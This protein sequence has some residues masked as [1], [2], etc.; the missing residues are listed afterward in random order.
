MS[1]NGGSME[2]RLLEPLVAYRDRYGREFGQNAA[3]KFEELLR[4]SSVNVWKNR[5]TVAA[6]RAEEAKRKEAESASGRFSSFTVLC[7][8]IAAFCGVFAILS[9]I[10]ASI[11]QADLGMWISFIVTGAALCVGASL[12][13]AK[14]LAPRK[15]ESGR[16]AE[17]YGAR[18]E[19]CMRECLAQLAP[20]EALYDDVLL[21]DLIR[22]TVPEIEL[23]ASVGAARSQY[24]R[25]HFGAAY[26]EPEKMFVGTL[27]GE[28]LGNPFIVGRKLCHRMGVRTYSE[29][30]VITWETTEVDAEGHP[31]TEHHSEVLTGYV[32]KPCPYFYGE[33][34]LEFYSE[35]APDLTFSRTPSHAERFSE[36]EIERKVRKGSKKI[37][38][39]QES[40]PGFTE[41]GNA[42]FDV[43][44]GALD[45]N[46]E[47]QFR[48]LFTPLAQKNLLSLMRGTEGFGDDF[49]M[50]KEGMKTTVVSEHSA[51]WDPDCGRFLASLSGY[52]VALAREN[53]L[54]ETL[55][56]FRNL[57]F[58]LAPILSIPLFGQTRPSVPPA[59]ARR[60]V[61][62][63]EA[64]CAAYRMGAS[65]R[66]EEA[67]T[68]CYFKTQLIRTVGKTDV[69]RVHAYGYRTEERV[70]TV[71]EYG[72][73][74]YLHDIDVPWTE[75]FPV[76]R[77]TTVVLRE[78]GLSLL[79]FGKTVRGGL[80]EV[81]GKLGI[82]RMCYGDGILCCIAE[83]P[84]RFD[85]TFSEYMDNRR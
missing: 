17:E 57:Y 76:E 61:S 83:D 63:E 59:P 6:Y 44:F 75:Y 48:L 73:D 28:L 58:D 30:I 7:G 42:E 11:L 80:G 52:S 8:C 84:E 71:T 38:R 51:A 54:G 35:A 40:T 82:E 14:Y 66:P 3:D 41:L 1:I 60:A 34:A 36:G 18:A 13:A 49:T 50:K 33:T 2:D 39:I 69:V 70:E 29:S 25:E 45:R 5:E 15:K 26:C 9:C 32:T 65:L 81:F 27:S 10:F 23:S 68:E 64:E 37:S 55:A 12:F 53:F 85:R 46:H 56:Y 4:A 16:K 72:G 21:P 20:L 77:E 19:E 47:V 79:D 22:K 31:R 24:I 67:D 62:E 43:L 78:L 74:G